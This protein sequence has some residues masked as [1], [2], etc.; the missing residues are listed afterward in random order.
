MESCG[1]VCPEGH[2]GISFWKTVS[3]TQLDSLTDKKHYCQACGHDAGGLI[4]IENTTDNLLSVTKLQTTGTGSSDVVS[5]NTVMLM[6]Y[7]NEFDSL[8]VVAYS[9]RAP[10]PEVEE[11][12]VTEPEATEPDVTEPEETEPETPDVEIEIENPEPAP[13]QKPEEKPNT[14]IRDLVKKIF[15]FLSKWF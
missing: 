7:A 9:L 6:S 4:I 3:D 1:V 13:E 5:V 14:G 10:K 8:P 15:G 12:E 11:P 2:G